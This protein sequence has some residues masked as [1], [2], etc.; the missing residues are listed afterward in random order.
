MKLSYAKNSVICHEDISLGIIPCP[1][2]DI[3]LPL[4]DGDNV[5][6]C[7]S[8]YAVFKFKF[9]NII[10]PKHTVLIITNENGRNYQVIKSKHCNNKLIV[11]RPLKGKQFKIRLIK[12]ERDKDKD[13]DKEIENDCK[14]FLVVLESASYAEEHKNVAGGYDDKGRIKQKNLKILYPEVYGWT[15]MVGQTYPDNGRYMNGTA[16]LLGDSSYLISN[17]HV[18]ES[19]IDDSDTYIGWTTFLVD[20]EDSVNALYVEPGGKMIKIGTPG[21]P[22]IRPNDINDDYGIVTLDPFDFKY[23]RLSELTG[24]LALNTDDENTH[25][26]EIAFMPGFPQR[27]NQQLTSYYSANNLTQQSSIQSTVNKQIRTDCYAEGGNSGSP[28]I[29]AKTHRVLGLLW[30]VS[31]GRDAD[32]ANIFRGIKGSHVWE[33][34]KNLL[35]KK[36]YNSAT[37]LSEKYDIYPGQILINADEDWV[38]FRSFKEDVYYNGFSGALLSLKNYTLVN[39]KARNSLNDHIIDLTLRVAQRTD[40]GTFSIDKSHGS[41][42]SVKELV[43]CFKSEDNQTVSIAN[44]V[45][46]MWCGLEGRLSATEEVQSYTIFSIDVV[47]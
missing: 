6:V 26:G 47:V 10:I 31:S 30:G 19:L 13:K 41:S 44:G 45:Y 11:T 8:R 43:V 42:G 27:Y 36:E 40:K 18:Y 23:S 24:G 29:S 22:F 3:S 39:V 32:S 28:V 16:W 1:C 7:F 35:D 21:S 14:P 2:V 38:I 17:A 34:V 12:T 33:S 46:H 20:P 25:I 5:S 9:T 15:R 37:G 4:I